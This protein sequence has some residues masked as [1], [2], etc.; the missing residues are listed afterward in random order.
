MELIALVV[1]TCKT[2]LWM[3]AAVLALWLTLS[4]LRG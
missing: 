1:L 4:L 3:C 2:V